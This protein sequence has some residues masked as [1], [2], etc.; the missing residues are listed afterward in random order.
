VQM[1]SE[2]AILTSRMYAPEVSEEDARVLEN[3]TP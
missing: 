1:T 3:W 2:M